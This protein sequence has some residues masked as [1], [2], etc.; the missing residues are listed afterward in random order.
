MHTIATVLTQGVHPKRNKH[1]TITRE[2]VLTIQ[3]I[4]LY[5]KCYNYIK[6]RYRH[7][8]KRRMSSFCMLVTQLLICT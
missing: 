4:R 2:G 7:T 6:V 8:F 1:K 3:V 5:T